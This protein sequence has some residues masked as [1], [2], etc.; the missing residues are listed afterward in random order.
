MTGPL[1]AEYLQAVERALLAGMGRGL[2]LSALDLDH[3]HRWARAGIPVE[4]VVAGIEKAFATKPRTTRGL[5]YA[6]PAVDAAI[7]VW[8][9]RRVLHGEELGSVGRSV[10]LDAFEGGGVESDGRERDRG[11]DARREEGHVEAHLARERVEHGG[12]E[13]RPRRAGVKAFDQ[14]GEVHDRGRV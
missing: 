8:L 14:R 1:T 2:M 13:L 11:R 9:A 10:A 6:A 12:F 5:A 4:V 7:K 3:V